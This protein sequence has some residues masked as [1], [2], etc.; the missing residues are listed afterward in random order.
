MQPPNPPPGTAKDWLRRAKGKLALARLPLPP[1]GFL[2]DLCFCAQQASE[3]AIK[4]VYQ[5]H[6]WRFAYVHDLHWLLNGLRQSGLNI[7]QDV[8]EADQLS[9]YAA[10]TRY[11]GLYAPVTQSQYEEAVRIADTVINWAENLIP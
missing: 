5:Q 7:P 9:G 1:G 8:Q 4:A 10:Q 3:L 6:S 2:E 11:P